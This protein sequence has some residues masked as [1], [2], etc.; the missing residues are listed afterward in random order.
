MAKL[1]S[2]IYTILEKKQR[3]LYKS[4]DAGNLPL[5]DVYSVF[6]ECGYKQ[7]TANKWLLNWAVS[8]RLCFEIQKDGKYK[9]RLGDWRDTDMSPNDMLDGGRVW[10]PCK[11]VWISDKGERK[12]TV[13]I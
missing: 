8:M 9:V 6:A 10:L 11:E 13:I 2:T 5:G 7:S 3:Q 12:Q 1:P 4:G